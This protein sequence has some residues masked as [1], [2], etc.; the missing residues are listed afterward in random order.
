MRGMTS[1]SYM[2]MVVMV[3]LMEMLMEMPPPK[4]RRSGDVDGVD[5]PFAR[6]T[7]AAGSTLSWSRRGLSPPLPPQ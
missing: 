2:E 3:M 6:G 4:P 1:I 7:G 5:F